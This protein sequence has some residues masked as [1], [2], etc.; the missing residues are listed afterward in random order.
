MTVKE[1][2]ELRMKLLKELYDHNEETGGEEKEISRNTPMTAEEK[3][4]F[5]AYEY[6]NDKEL[7]YFK[8]LHKLA[9]E[10]K[11]T[12]KGIDFVE[13]TLDLY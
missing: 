11:I 1:K 7:I 4:I 2:Q 9:Y 13:E 6:L 10:A 12:H 5:L 8:P 3:N